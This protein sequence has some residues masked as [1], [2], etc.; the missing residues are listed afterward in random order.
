MAN[1]NS[2]P[3]ATLSRLAIL[4]QA[5]LDA[6]TRDVDCL[7]SAQ[8]GALTGIPAAQVRKDLSSFGEHGVPGVGY[9]VDDLLAS[10]ARCLKIDQTRRFAL[11]GAGRLGQALASYTGLAKMNFELVMA[12]DND[13]AKIGKHAGDALIEPVTEMPARLKQE[14]IKVIVL[15][16]PASAAQAT[17]EAAI[18]GGARWILNFTPAILKVPDDCLVRDVSFTNEFAV[19]AHYMEEG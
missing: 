3:S 18:S 6:K 5:L 8:I 12:F 15:T 17:A 14:A 10:I 19:L 2:I 4:Y 9:R 7:S 16:V 13:P 1:D 11:V